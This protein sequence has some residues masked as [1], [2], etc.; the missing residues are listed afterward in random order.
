MKDGLDA[1]YTYTPVTPTYTASSHRKRVVRRG[2]DDDDDDL[3][4]D[5]DELDIPED[6]DDEDWYAHKRRR[7]P[8]VPKSERKSMV[9]RNVSPFVRPKPLEMAEPRLVA[10]RTVAVSQHGGGGAA[11]GSPMVIKTMVKS[12]PHLVALQPKP[13]KVMV[14]QAVSVPKVVHQVVD[15]SKKL[16][17][18]LNKQK[19]QLRED[20]LRK[21][22]QFEQELKHEIQEEVNSKLVVIRGT[23]GG[24]GKKDQENDLSTPTSTP[25]LEKG[26]KRVSGSSTAAQARKELANDSFSAEESPPKTAKLNSSSSSSG[27]GG[28][29]AKK[30]QR[31]HHTAT[32]STGAS[33]APS[34]S[35][36]KEK[37]LCICRT[38]Y[39]KNK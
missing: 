14:Q 12:Q 21:R 25:V 31:S 19:D 22:E 30:T 17:E 37:L 24:D 10:Q 36:K 7:K 4:D 13:Q 35:K 11:V 16:T 5:M 32:P 28:S 33:T 9:Q 38:P 3:D 34:S 8:Y 23:T 18:V 15:Q 1:P 20:I 26:R 27:K 39:D 29:A 6:D 2:A